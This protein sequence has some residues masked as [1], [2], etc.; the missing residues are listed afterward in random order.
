MN[1][2]LHIG[3][4]PALALSEVLFL[5]E[6]AH[7]P[8][9]VEWVRDGLVSISCDERPDFLSCDI[10][11]GT[12]KV[13][14]SIGEINHGAQ[15]IA[16][17]LE[18]SAPHGK[19]TFGLNGWF[20]TEADGVAHKTKSALR[21]RGRVVRYVKGK[22]GM[23]DAA[24][25]MHNGLLASG[26]DLHLI[27]D[28]KRLLLGRTLSVQNVDAWSRRDYEKPERDA[29]RGMLPPKL[30]R[31]MINMSG[32]RGDGCV[33][34]P[35]CGMGT[36]LMEAVLLQHSASGSDADPHAVEAA[37]TNLEW[38][39][40]EYADVPHIDVLQAD[41]RAVAKRITKKIDVIVTETFLGNPHSL[42]HAQR[43]QHAVTLAD[44][45]LD[46]LKNWRSLLASGHRVVMAIPLYRTSQ[47]YVR[48]PL[49]GRLKQIGYQRV[50]P[51]VSAS[52][53][54]DEF[55]PDGNLLYG[56]S[57]QRV[58]REILVLERI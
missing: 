15:Q 41:A 28:G 40:A 26:G 30:A 54:G 52:M 18:H 23:L 36:V 5:S 46:S 9:R 57:D 37:R 32:V 2:F 49:F 20:G 27:P 43:E 35:F 4:E 14:E 47:G 16:D 39:R 3:R 53:V 31:I 21:E 12:I 42:T 44:L 48:I 22:N 6:D 58:L 13:V 51:P 17:I 29:K 25:V 55:S 34:D 33:F 11:G 50:S 45:Y 24:T 7:V 8:I 38:L 19:V 56:R 1:F 10:L